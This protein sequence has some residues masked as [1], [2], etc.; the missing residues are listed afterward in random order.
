MP[1]PKKKRSV[2]RPPLFSD[3]KPTGVRAADL[4]LVALGLDEF[5]AIRLA[6]HE[7]LD[8]AESAE[9]MGISRSTF[10]RLVEK[11]RF[12][13]AQFV[14]D[15]RRLQIEGGDVHFR[16]NLI[17]CHAC[18]HMFSM[19]F[20]ADVSECPS[21]GSKNLIDLAGGYGHGNCCRRH[22]HRNRR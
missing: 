16:G 13:I 1:R 17:E 18:G 19:A 11:A 12:K 7:G 22:Q 15:G 3:F 10:S 20:G 8:H 9:Q 2:R 14:I 4:Q 6:D 21:C 5:E